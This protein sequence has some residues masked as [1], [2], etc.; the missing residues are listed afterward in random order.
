MASPR[1]PG[2]AHLRHDGGDPPSCQS[3]AA[4]KNET[5]NHGKNKTNA[6][7]SLIDGQSRKFGASPSGSLESAS[8]APTSSHGLSG[9]ELTRRSL[10][11]HTSRQNDNCNARSGPFA[12]LAPLCLAVPGKF[13]TT[14]WR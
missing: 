9:A 3:A 7:S 13:P 4:K 2:D 14:R 10:S 1:F 11:A 12:L 6:V 5:P 8:N